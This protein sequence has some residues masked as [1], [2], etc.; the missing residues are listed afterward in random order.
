MCDIVFEKAK[1]RGRTVNRASVYANAAI[2]SV[3]WKRCSSK[4]RRIHKKTSVPESL[5][6]IFLWILRN[7]EEHLFLQNSTGRL[8]LIIA[9][10]IV[11]KGLLA[12]ET[13]KYETRTKAYVLIWASSV[14]YQKGH[15]R[16]KNRC[17]K[18]AFWDFKLGVLK[19]Y[20]NSIEKHLF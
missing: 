13:V 2:R 8:L 3:L 5:F 19:K 4:F 10:S 12:N 20:V 11:A 18:L 17:Q 16:W 7:L 15:S 6:G 1:G 9:V 14:T